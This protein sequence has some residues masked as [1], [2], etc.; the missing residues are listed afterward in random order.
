MNTQMLVPQGTYEQDVPTEY[1]SALYAV[2]VR[3]ATGDT[4]QD[5]IEG[6]GAFGRTT[7]YKWRKCYPQWVESVERRARADVAEQRREMELAIAALSAEVEIAVRRRVLLQA[8]SVIGR[9]IDIATDES[10]APKDATAAA[11]ALRTFMVE[12][13]SYARKEEPPAEETIYT[14]LPFNPHTQSLVNAKIE[15]PP[16]S[17]VNIE[18]PDTIDVTPED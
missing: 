10:M 17:H 12:G 5:A 13:F 4:I 8:E 14:G 7:F 1:E 2:F 3:V 6:V 16:G 15:L 11:R 9:Q 18:T